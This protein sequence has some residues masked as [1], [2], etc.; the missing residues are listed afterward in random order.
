MQ[1][2]VDAFWHQHIWDW[3]TLLFNRHG[4]Y[5]DWDRARAWPA[6]F[7][8]GPV[9]MI[10]DSALYFVNTGSALILAAANGHAESGQAIQRALLRVALHV[11]PAG[12]R[13]AQPRE[14]V[15]RRERAV[16]VDDQAAPPAVRPVIG[17]A[18]HAFEPAQRRQR[19]DMAR[20]PRARPRPVCATAWD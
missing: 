16:A 17:D 13:A 18:R 7:T 10:G 19:G 4:E 5:E 15:E 1:R 3:S 14:P 2:F 9:P 11:Q 6:D 20:P 8:G 12:Q